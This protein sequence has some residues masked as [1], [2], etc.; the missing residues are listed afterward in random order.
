MLNKNDKSPAFYRDTSNLQSSLDSNQVPQADAKDITNISSSIKEFRKLNPTL[1]HV[2]LNA[3]GPLTLAF[4]E[5]YDEGWL[6]E[7]YANGQIIDTV[8]SK[9][10]YGSINSFNISRIS[11][12]P[13]GMGGGDK[14]G[15]TEIN[16]KIH[17]V[18]RYERQ[19]WFEI[20][21]IISAITV[22]VSCTIII[23]SA[24]RNRKK[25]IAA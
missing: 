20:G 6:A 25:V 23:I 21:I 19:Y 7:I 9:P 1:W 2:D 3:S 16:D 18:L 11:P 24:T 5:P 15:T 17:V 22:V 4:A 12:D 8:R 10:L 13:Q 14:E